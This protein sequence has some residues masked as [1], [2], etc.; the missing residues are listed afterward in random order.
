MSAHRQTFS[1]SSKHKM[2]SI[3][4]T[5]FETLLLLVTNRSAEL[6]RKEKPERISYPNDKDTATMQIK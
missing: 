6:I 4:I 2:K 3:E 5:V 1:K